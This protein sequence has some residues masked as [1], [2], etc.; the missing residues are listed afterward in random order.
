MNTDIKS[1]SA[2]T[3]V[4][5]HHATA[6]DQIEAIGTASSTN[7]NKHKVAHANAQNTIVNTSQLAEDK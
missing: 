6:N 3:D 4:T 7:G 5:N 2:G 1:D